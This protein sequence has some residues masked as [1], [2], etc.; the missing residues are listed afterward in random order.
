MKKYEDAIFEGAWVAPLDDEGLD[1]CIK[2]GTHFPKQGL[3]FIEGFGSYYAMESI[4]SHCRV[5][6]RGCAPSLG[7]LSSRQ[8]TNVYKTCALE[9]S[10]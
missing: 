1:Y 9:V 10:E 3:H 5:V 8:L 2:N 6:A 7:G 4:E